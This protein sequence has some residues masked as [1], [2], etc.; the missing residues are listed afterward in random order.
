MSTTVPACGTVTEILFLAPS[1]GASMVS[2]SSSFKLPVDINSQ[3][4]QMKSPYGF[5][6]VISAF[7]VLPTLTVNLFGTAVTVCS[8]TV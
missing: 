4:Y 8:G 6:T 1:M 3:S 2:I 5:S 7:T